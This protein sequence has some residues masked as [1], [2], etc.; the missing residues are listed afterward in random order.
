MEGLLTKVNGMWDRDGGF[1]IFLFVFMQKM[2]AWQ[3]F[4]AIA[5]PVSA[6][7]FSVFVSELTFAA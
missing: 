1:E 2:Q 5:G 4:A 6:K 7:L 3:G